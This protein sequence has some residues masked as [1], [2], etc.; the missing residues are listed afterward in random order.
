MQ[1]SDTYLIERVS[2]GIEPMQ[3][4]IYNG[5][6]SDREEHFCV[7]RFEGLPAEILQDLQQELPRFTGQMTAFYKRKGRAEKSA[8]RIPF[9]MAGNG[10][11]ALQGPGQTIEQ[12]RAEIEREYSDRRRTE[13]T[14][15]LRAEIERIRTPA[16][17]LAVILE[18][19][20]SKLL[21]LD[22][23]PVQAVTAGLNG[24][25]N[26]VAEIKYF[27][28]VEL[29]TQK[30]GK[31]TIIQLASKLNTQPQLIELVKNFVK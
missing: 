29:I 18:A 21:K 15:E 10:V 3:L 31:Q 7:R 26:D 22:L 12:M 28:A 24:T 17:H 14:E 2:K 6:I 4:E 23:P 30:L 11:T 25:E 16:G 5:N 9:F 19:T 1:F 13:E 20:L 27:E 8:E